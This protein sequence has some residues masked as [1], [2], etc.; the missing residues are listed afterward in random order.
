MPTLGSVAARGGCVLWPLVHY[1]RLTAEKVVAEFNTVR[2]GKLIM[3]DRSI[4]LRS[5]IEGVTEE[6][7]EAIAPLGY[8][9]E[10]FK[11]ITSITAATN[12]YG[13]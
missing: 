3:L 10:D 6:Q 8:V 13:F 5:A 11:Q 7:L 12:R 2:N 1:F 9:S 4:C